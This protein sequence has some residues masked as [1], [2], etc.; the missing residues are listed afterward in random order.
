MQLCPDCKSDTVERTSSTTLR[1]IGC[2]VLIFIIP[3]GLFFAW[4][5]FVLPHTFRCHNCKRQGNESDLMHVDW[6]E[7]DELLAED[8]QLGQKLDPLKEYWFEQ[9]ASLYKITDVNHMYILVKVSEASTTAFQIHDIIDNSLQV[10]NLDT[11][12]EPFTYTAYDWEPTDFGKNLF[13][14]AEMELIVKRDYRGLKEHL[15]KS[16]RLIQPFHVIE[17]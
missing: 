3:F 10:K 2:L 1:V 7:R 14:A 6:R 5:P 13:T 8:R 17:R 12:L 16:N 9:M 4:I 15:Q 11:R